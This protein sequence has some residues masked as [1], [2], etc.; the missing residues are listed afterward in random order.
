MAYGADVGP[1]S[2][3]RFATG[4]VALIVVYQLGFVKLM[5]FGAATAGGWGI[6]LALLVGGFLTALIF[7]TVYDGPRAVMRLIRPSRRTSGIRAR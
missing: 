2:A 3:G 5:G 6:A 1:R 4:L 7:T